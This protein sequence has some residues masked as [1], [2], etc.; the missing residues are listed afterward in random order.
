MEIRLPSFMNLPLKYHLIAGLFIRVLLIA[1]GDYHDDFYDV[2]YTDVDYKVFTD[3]AR[4]VVHGDS[5]YKRHTY[6]YSPIVA[7][8]LTPNIF[9]QKNFGKILFSIFDILVTVAVKKLVEHHLSRTW[10]DKNEASKVALYC[11]FFWIYNPMSIGI[12]TRGNADSITS[13]FVILSLLVLQTNIVLGFWKYVWSGILLGVSIH[14]RLYP[15]AFSYP[16]YLSIGEYKITRRTRLAEGVLYLLPNVEQILLS[17][18][19]IF[20][21]IFLTYG[22]YLIYG[23]EFLFETYIYHLFRKDT[24]HN[25]SVLFYYSYLR[26][27]DPSVDIVKLIAHVFE[28]LILFA[29][30]LTFGRKPHTLPFALF[31]QAVVLV[32]FNSVMTSQYFI[33]FMSLLPLVI[34]SFAMERCK[35]LLLGFVWVTSQSAWLAFAYLLEFKSADVFIF[36]WFKSVILFCGHI[37]ILAQMIRAYAPFHGFGLIK[38][39]N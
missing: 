26:M 20:T 4:H 11:S 14:L 17:M 39:Y 36:I 38:K 21:L 12:S 28:F 6:R 18:S 2:P 16:M 30:S 25:F 10:K 37:F 34:H 32:A 5:P 19:C 7:Y 29:L 35:G 1:Y 24:R 8:M 13:F 3:A 31:S 9:F 15:L 33:W 23:Y 22:M 27:D